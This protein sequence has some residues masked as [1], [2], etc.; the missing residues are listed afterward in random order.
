MEDQDE[1]S[2]NST[3][4]GYALKSIDQWPTASSSNQTKKNEILEKAHDAIILCL[5]YK[6]IREVSKEKSA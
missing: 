2:S 4:I 1:C 3:W 5:G 6:P